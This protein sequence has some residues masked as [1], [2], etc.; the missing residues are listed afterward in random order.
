MKEIGISKVLQNNLFYCA[1]LKI[2][3]YVKISR[4]YKKFIKLKEVIE[5]MEF[6]VV[7][8]IR[9][10]TNRRHV[11]PVCTPTSAQRLLQRCFRHSF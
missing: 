1:F 3:S 6:I 9:V 4:T 7:F 10:V 8:I 5:A 11:T 2:I